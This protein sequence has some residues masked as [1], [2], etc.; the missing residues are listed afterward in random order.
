MKTID[1]FLDNTPVQIKYDTNR[2]SRPIVV[3]GLVWFEWEQLSFLQQEQV[4]KQIEKEL[5]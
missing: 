5:T 3:M 2:F 1:G 4:L